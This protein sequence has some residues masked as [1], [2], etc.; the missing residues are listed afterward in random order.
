M[1]LFISLNMLQIAK[2]WDFHLSLCL[3]SP[4][5]PVRSLVVVA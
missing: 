2:A 5:R 1:T 4:Y 3:I